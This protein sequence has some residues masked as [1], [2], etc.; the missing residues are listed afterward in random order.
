VLTLSYVLARTTAEQVTSA[1]VYGESRIRC[2]T[3]IGSSV[4]VADDVRQLA[5]LLLKNYVLRQTDAL[6]AAGADVQN[7]IKLQV[8]C[9][10][11][12]CNYNR[13]NPLMRLPT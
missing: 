10:F 7:Y 1:V 4:Q 3:P 11:C 5:G 6:I 8:T 13:G 9:P 2:L 12:V